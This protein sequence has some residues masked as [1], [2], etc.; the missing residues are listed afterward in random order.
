[1]R[2]M[3]SRRRGAQRP[4]RRVIYFVKPDRLDLL[5]GIKKE[6]PN[7]VLCDAREITMYG[8]NEASSDSLC[9]F[10]SQDAEWVEEKKMSASLRETD[11]PRSRCEKQNCFGHTER[12]CSLLVFFLL[13]T[14]CYGFTLPS[15]CFS[16]Q[17]CV[18]R[19]TCLALL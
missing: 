15:A 17:R 5:Q 14:D 3:T 11:E 18:L 2:L 7:T 1:M 16:Q 13:R 9:V 4:Q 6:N 19:S 8:R 12:V 10:V